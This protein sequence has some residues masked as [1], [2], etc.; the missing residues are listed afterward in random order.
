MKTTIL[1]KGTHCQ[2][3]KALIENVCRET[4]GVESCIVDFKTGQTEIHHTDALNWN[5]LKREIESLGQYRVE[6]IIA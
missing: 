1:I 6:R 4:P 2:A 3:C 5:A